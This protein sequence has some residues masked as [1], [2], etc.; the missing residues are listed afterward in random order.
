MIAFDTSFL[1][2]YLDGVDT[3]A[4]YLEANERKPFFAPSL[5]LFEVYRGVARVGGH[6]GIECVASGLDWIEP[7]PLT[8]SAVREAALI[9]TELL[10]AGNRISLGDTLIAGICRHNDARVVTRD[11]HFERV[12][13][14][15]VENY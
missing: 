3:A 4:A 9:E 13:G 10:D 8:D 7:L 15:T 2:D 14:L 5:A 6:D 11:S 1:L 12:D